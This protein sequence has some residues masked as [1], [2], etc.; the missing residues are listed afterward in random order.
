VCEAKRIDYERVGLVENLGVPVTSAGQ[1][2]L[3]KRSKWMKK[4]LKSG[5]EGKNHSL[6]SNFC[7]CLMILDA[8]FKTSGQRNGPPHREQIIP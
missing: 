5:L 7:A 3:E 6:K 4:R 1:K 2:K 8:G